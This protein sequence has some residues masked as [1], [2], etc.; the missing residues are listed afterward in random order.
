MPKIPVIDITKLALTDKL[1]NIPSD[2][3]IL[4][5]PSCNKL[6]SPSSGS[7]VSKSITTVPH[8]G[9]DALASSLPLGEAVFFSVSNFVSNSLAAE[10]SPN[11]D[12]AIKTVMIRPMPPPNSEGNSTL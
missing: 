12:L 1:P 4:G 5:S 7:R 6:L 10:E 2:A 8:K 3:V 11:P 9:K